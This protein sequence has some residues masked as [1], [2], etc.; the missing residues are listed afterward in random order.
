MAP[1]WLGLLL[2]LYL[3]KKKTKKKKLQLFTFSVDIPKFLFHLSLP[4][5]V[6]IIFFSL[7]HY[8]SISAAISLAFIKSLEPIDHSLQILT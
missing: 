5:T 3:V 4:N 7:M 6:C 1:F 2:S 8:F